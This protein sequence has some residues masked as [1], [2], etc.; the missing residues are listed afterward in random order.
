[1]LDFKLTDDLDIVVH[2]G[3]DGEQRNNITTV[4]TAFFTDARVGG[5][6]GYWLNTSASELWIHEQARVTE[7]SAKE[8]TESAKGIAAELVEQGVFERIDAE[9]KLHDGQMRLDIRCYNDGSLVER[10]A[11]NV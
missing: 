11:F 2:L 6:R 7:L 3:A 8:M 10:R 5:K 4:T 1:M 9:V